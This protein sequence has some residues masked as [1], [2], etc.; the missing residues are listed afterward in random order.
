M[1]RHRHAEDDSRGSND[2]K[3][4]NADSMGNNLIRTYIGQPLV[5]AASDGVA[6][7]VSS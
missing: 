3:L 2:E 6:A 1:Q 7:L 5:V 4:T